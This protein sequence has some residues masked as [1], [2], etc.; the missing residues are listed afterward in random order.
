MKPPSDLIGRHWRRRLAAA[1]YCVGRSKGSGVPHPYRVPQP[2]LRK[3]M[4]EVSSA[5][6]E[7]FAIS[8]NNE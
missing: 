6:L 2:R 8:V 3:D 1:C 7:H 5:L 4:P